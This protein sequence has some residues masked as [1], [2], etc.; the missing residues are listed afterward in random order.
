MLYPVVE[1]VKVNA[2][3]ELARNEPP[4]ISTD[5]PWGPVAEF[6]FTKLNPVPLALIIGL[7]M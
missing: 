7:V 4:T 1:L 3:P 6:K 5:G 2:L